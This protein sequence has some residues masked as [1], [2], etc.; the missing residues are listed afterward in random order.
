MNHWLRSA[1][2]DICLLVISHFRAQV[3]LLRNIG[4]CYDQSLLRLSLV[5]LSWFKTCLFIS[6]FVGRP[7]YQILDLSFGTWRLE[8][9]PLG[10]P[11]HIFVWLVA[12][13]VFVI[14]NGLSERCSLFTIITN[15]DSPSFLD[16]ANDICL[17]RS[18]FQF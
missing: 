7:G 14:S 10:R 11:F 5:F 9:P 17:N 3:L 18:L 1:C 15:L 13:K 16:M 6:L 12:S 2:L 8:A 4:R